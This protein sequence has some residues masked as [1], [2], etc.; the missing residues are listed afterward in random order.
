MPRALFLCGMGALFCALGTG[1]KKTQILGFS[2]SNLLF[3]LNFT[4][5]RQVLRG[6]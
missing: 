1:D 3:Y 6:L 5:Y 2:Y 4:L